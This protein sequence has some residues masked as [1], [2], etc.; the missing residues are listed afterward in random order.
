MIK[1]LFFN[2][3]SWFSGF[4]FSNCVYKD[5]VMSTNKTD[6]CD[7]D[8][9]IFNH[10]SLPS[11]PP[12]K[13]HRQKWIFT[14]SE[15][16]HYGVKTCTTPQWRYK[17]DWIMSYRRDS[18]FFFGYGDIVPK[19]EMKRKNYEKIYEQKKKLVAW[20]VSHCFT[21]SK[22]EEYV[23]EMSKIAKVD[24]FGSCGSYKCEKFKGNEND[25]CH[26][27]VARDYKFILAF[28]NSLCRDY[29]SEK[30]YYAYEYDKPI[31][32]VVLGS[33]TLGNYSQGAVYIDV[34]KFRTPLHL[35]RRLLA[36]GNNREY[37]IDLLKKKDRFTSLTSNQTFT[38]AM[39]KMCESLTLG[40]PGRLDLDIA[41][42]F[43][44]EQ[45]CHSP[46]QI[47]IA[48]K[49]ETINRKMAQKYLNRV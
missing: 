4:D 49:T 20:I 33:F 43:F 36:L 41:E 39:C 2:P 11:Y 45:L 10:A 8:A 31:I 38:S 30:F 26:D 47:G 48:S 3:P 15:S 27:L 7:N 40:R 24:V 13:R 5:C 21:Q 28:E 9:V 25:S 23:E 42:W 34:H 17:F 22:R 32:P 37:Y 18:D 1:I 12:L 46:D 19:K 29:T 35:T 44:K 14:C 6:F 16:A